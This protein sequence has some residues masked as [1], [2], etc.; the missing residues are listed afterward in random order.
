[1]AWGCK[2]EMSTVD[3]EKVIKFIR[4]KALKGPEGTVAKQGQYDFELIDL[5]KAPPGS[6]QQDSVLCPNM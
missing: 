4:E 1:M 6:D 3:E 2:L 5:A